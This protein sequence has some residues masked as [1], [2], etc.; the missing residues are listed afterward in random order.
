MGRW[1]MTSIRTKADKLNS[2]PSLRLV[3]WILFFPCFFLMD[4]NISPAIYVIAGGMCLYAL[5]ILFFPKF[6]AIFGRL[7]PFT[8]LPDIVGIS[9]LIYFERKYALACSLFYMVPLFS[10]ALY[11]K[12]LST[13]LTTTFSSIAFI[14]VALL[15]DLYLPVVILQIIIFFIL[16]F[17]LTSLT[18]MFHESYFVLANLDALTK[19]HNRRYF[20]H[21]LNS[22]VEKQ[23][24]FSL[25]LLDLDNFKHLND[26][27]GHDHGDF[28]LKIIA[29]I[30]K[31]CTRATDIIARYGGD[32]F[33]II[34]PQTS[35]ESSKKIAERIRNNVLV[36]PKFLPY[37]AK[38]SLS[39][40]I[41]AYPDDGQTIEE[42]QQK[43]DEALY[44]AKA[45]GK[46]YIHLY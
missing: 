45:R 31:E 2:V 40:G 32:E 26:T 1:A 38:V 12:T 20:N 30:M 9:L 22:L 14:L 29:G 17:Y 28:V 23:I 27:E 10:L 6:Q 42:I 33:A 3:M 41:A 25:I 19:I 4:K 46:N 21:S 16:S 7:S 24:P 15:I 18:K 13:Y 5:A 35:K 43:V 39:M 11:N 36:N 37:N 8:F 34:S 44:V